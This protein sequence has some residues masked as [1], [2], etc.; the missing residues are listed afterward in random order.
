[1]SVVCNEPQGDTTS[2]DFFVRTIL[3]IPHLLQKLLQLEKNIRIRLWKIFM[4][5]RNLK[6]KGAG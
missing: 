6:N 3:R 5:V 1:M 4:R 2:S